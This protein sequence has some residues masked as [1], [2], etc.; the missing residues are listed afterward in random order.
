MRFL[1]FTLSLVFLIGLVGDLS[2]G[3]WLRAGWDVLLIGF[4]GWWFHDEHRKLR[5]RRRF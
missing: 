4:C 1:P 5:T 3:H 2:T